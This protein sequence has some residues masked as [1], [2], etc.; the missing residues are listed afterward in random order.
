MEFNTVIQRR[1]STR[2]FKNKT[3][4]WKEVLEAIDAAI[5]GPFAANHNHLKFLIIED[6]QKIKKI[7]EHCEQDWIETAPTVILVCSDDTHLENIFSDRGRIYS[8]QQSGAAIQTV[9]LKLTDL[10]ISSCWVG[11]YQDSIIREIL[12]V[13]GHIQIEAIIP[14][15]YSADSEKKKE[16]RALDTVLFW[17]KWGMDRRPTELERQKII[18]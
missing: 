8:R 16:K 1:K 18:R 2:Q 17:E 12:G 4:S 10:G 13:P 6:K 15:G 9:C 3:I 7:A 5:Q 11:A 14:A